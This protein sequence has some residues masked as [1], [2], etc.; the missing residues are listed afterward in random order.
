[1]EIL[2]YTPEMQRSIARCYNNLTMNVPHCYPV[3]EDELGN[4]LMCPAYETADKKLLQTQTTFVARK[5]KNILG[6]T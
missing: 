5:G 4:V 6:F 3:S 2:E 1:M